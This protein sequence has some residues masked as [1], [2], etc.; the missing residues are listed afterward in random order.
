MASSRVLKARI[1]ATEAQVAAFVGDLD[2][3]VRDELSRI[4]KKAISGDISAKEA[5]RLLGRVFSELEKAGLSDKVKKAKA[6]YEDQ[7]ANVADDFRALGIKSAFSDADEATITALVNTDL[8]RIP[9]SVEKFTTDIRAAMMRTIIGGDAPSFPDL[10]GTLGGRLMGNLETELNTSLQAF[11]RT[12]TANKAEELGFEL[13]VYLGPDDSVTRD[14]C[15]E[16]LK[17]KAPGVKP[18]SVAIYTRDEIARMNNGQDLDVMTHGGG[19]NCRHQ[20][21][22]IDEEEAKRRGYD[23]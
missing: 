23:G 10:Y 17:G 16:C 9:A 21:R 1:K 4:L 19:Y 7:L 14:F 15:D 18:R 12:M 11:S 3:F 22:P 5:T 2:R 6:L 13:F 8:S 20:W